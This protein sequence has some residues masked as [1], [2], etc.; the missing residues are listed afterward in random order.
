MPKGSPEKHTPIFVTMRNTKKRISEML[1]FSHRKKT[2]HHKLYLAHCKKL[3]NIDL[4]ISFK[5]YID[6]YRYIYIHIYMSS[7]TSESGREER[8]RNINESY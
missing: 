4:K 5:K 3:A 1:S 6:I 7:L 2:I 8:E